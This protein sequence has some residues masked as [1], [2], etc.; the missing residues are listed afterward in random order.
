MGGFFREFNIEQGDLDEK[1]VFLVTLVDVDGNGYQDIFATTYGGS[2]YLVSNSDGDFSEAEVKE[3]SGDGRLLTLSAGFGDLDQDGDLDLALGNWSSGSEKLFSPEFSANE[4]L[5]Q[6]NGDYRRTVMDDIKGET[7]SVLITDLNG[8]QLADV[9]FGNDRLTPDFYY[10]GVGQG[11]FELIQRDDGVPLS[12]MFTMSLESAD[13]NNDLAMDVFSTDMSFAR[14]ATVDY[15]DQVSTENCQHWLEILENLPDLGVSVCKGSFNAPACVDAMSISA[16]QLLKDDRPCNA[17]TSSQSAQR[18]CRH[19]ART[20]AP[21]V[22][23]DVNAHIEQRQQNTLLLKSGD[24]F[25]DAANELGVDSSYWSWNASAADLDK[26]GWNDIYVG[27]GF[28]FG[29]GFYEVQPNRMFRN[30]SGAEFDDVAGSWG[31]DDLINTPSYTYIDYDLDG[32]L[33]IF[34]SG[35]MESPRLFEN[36]LNSHNSVSFRLR[37]SGK[38]SDAIGATVTINSGDKAQIKELSLS[39]GFMSYDHPVV[40]FGLAESKVVDKLTIVWPDGEQTTI[41]DPLEANHHYVVQ[42]R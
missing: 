28:H 22:A 1:N 31:L 38:N 18:L 5:Y 23:I 6:E 30:V 40:Y 8:D 24:S 11:Q 26:D 29:D 2:N 12:S 7:N 10:L 42:R 25:F 3:F 21:E 9:L 41:T 32:D 39:G 15:C 33:D 13:F 16:A 19:L 14:A 4:I 36:K 27:N 20:A 34:A 35:V 37:Q 17:I